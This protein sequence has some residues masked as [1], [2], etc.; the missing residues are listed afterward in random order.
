MQPRPAVQLGDYYGPQ[1]RKFAGD[2]ADVGP[3][4]PPPT[5]RYCPEAMRLRQAVGTCVHR[6]P[7]LRL[8]KVDPAT[9]SF[10]ITDK[11]SRRR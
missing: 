6:V 11:V 1:P 7:N 4:S 2:S 10:C 3:P 9:H 5:L 8:D